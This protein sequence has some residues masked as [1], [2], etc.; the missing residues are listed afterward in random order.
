MAH[1]IFIQ[2]PESIYDDRPG[3][4]Y[5]FPRQ[6]L[7][8]VEETVGDWIVFYEGKKGAFGYVAVQRVKEVVADPSRSDWYYAMLEPGSL[9]QFEQVVSRA[10]S[11]G[12]AYERS[13]RGSEG[14]PISGGVN[15]SAVR[16]LTEIEFAEIVNAGLEE[17]EGPDALPRSEQGFSEQQAP[18]EAVTLSPN[19]Q[20]VLSS[21]PLRDAAFARMVKR[22]YGGKCAIS[23][24]DLRNGGGRAEVQ[25]AH[26]RPVSHDGP[27]V[28]S[29]GL[30]LSG[31]LHWMFDR[32]LISISEDYS[33]LVSHNK[34][35]PDTVRRLIRPE[36]K[37]L[38]PSNDRD[39]PHPEYLRFHREEIFGQG[40]SD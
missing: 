26:I 32:G 37:L 6:Y 1:A 24:L 2:N 11:L 15:T 38:L 31:T 23:G 35:P 34:V 36:G 21:R 9:L 14:Q 17:I 39:R 40:L 19:R 7:G 16:R 25:A 3:R 22:A 10:N 12:V 18:F 8:M 20:K 28:V 30:A 13:L 27:D 33:I 29:N 4:A 5:N